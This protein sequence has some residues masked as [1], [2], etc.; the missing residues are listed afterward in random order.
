VLI[1]IS[2]SGN[3]PNLLA[4]THAAKGQ[5]ILTVGFLG[6]RGGQL[7]PIVDRT[8]IVPVESPQHVQECH[9]ALGHS[10]CLAIERCLFEE[11]ADGIP[12]GDYEA[13]VRREIDHYHDREVV[14]DLPEIF[15][16][17]SERYLRP[18]L[19]VVG[20]D[21]IESFFLEPI[22]AQCREKTSGVV[23]ISSIGAGNC[24]LE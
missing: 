4:A 9:A 3:S 15:H 2:T 5:G 19:R 17:W 21:S 10:V 24:D 12:S 8:V 20:I 6:G 22:V 16:Y 14:H 11:S 1:L 18:K 23:R 7:A 13:R